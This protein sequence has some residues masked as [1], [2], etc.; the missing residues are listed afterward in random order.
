M[1]L[2]VDRQTG[3]ESLDVLTL[4]HRLTRAYESEGAYASDEIEDDVTSLATLHATNQEAAP[5]VEELLY[6]IEDTQALYGIDD[7]AADA[8]FVRGTIALR[9][10][11]PFFP[12]TGRAIS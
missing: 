11:I 8:A 10:L 12:C 7:V 1:R 3:D 4:T 6:A 9:A 5:I 2:A